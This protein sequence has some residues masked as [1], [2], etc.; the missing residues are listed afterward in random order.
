MDPAQPEGRQSAGKPKGTNK[1][2]RPGNGTGVKVEGVTFNKGSTWIEL[3]LVCAYIIQSRGGATVAE[4]LYVI[5]EILFSKVRPNTVSDSLEALRKQ[6]ILAE[7]QNAEGH[8][9]FSMKRVKFNCNPEIAQVKSMV[10]E[11]KADA[12][13]QLII[14]R[15]KKPLGK[16]KAPRPSEPADFSLEFVILRPWLGAQ[17]WDGNQVLQ[18]LYFAA[19][20]WLTLHQ[21]DSKG[22]IKMKNG[23][24][25]Y[26]PE[27]SDHT[28]RPLMFDRTVD[29]KIIATHTHSIQHFLARAASAWSPS[30]ALKYKSQVEEFFGLTDIVCNPP[31]DMMRVSKGS[32]FR[33]GYGGQRIAAG[34]KNYEALK[35]GLRLEMEFVCPTK[36]FVDPA[37]LKFWLERVFRFPLRG[38]SPARGAQYRAMILKSMKYRPWDRYDEDWIEL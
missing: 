16:E 10:E 14:E 38:M 35:P 27:F 29:G 13:G 37:K 6:E 25:L 19:G 20:R 31:E 30:P 33:E 11:L 2:K 26:K 24:Y 3:L 34:L 9:V 21:T 4:V 8:R 28:E 22:K 18:D 36:D 15:F 32:I 7:G 12:A 23:A 5:T 17:V 1:K